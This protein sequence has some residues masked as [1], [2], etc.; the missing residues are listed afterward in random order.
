LYKAEDL[1]GALP[2]HWM[3]WP[4][5]G[6][7]AV[8]L[9][10]LI[11]PHALGV[12]YDV[13]GDL[14][15][16]HLTVRQVVAILLVK[17]IIWIIALASGTSGGVLA[18]LLIFGGCLGWLE[19]QVLPGNAG[20]WAL[21]SMAGMM[22]GTMR[23]PLTGI[24]FAIELTGDLAL[25][26]PLLAATGAAYAVT[27]LLLKRSILTEKIARRG[28]HVVR[29]YSIDPFELLRVSDVMVRDVDTLP[30]E[31][32]V[33]QAIA[34]FSDD[35]H[36]HKSYPI[37][38]RDRRVIGMV[39]RADILRW[40]TEPEAHG[41]TLFERHSDDQLVVGHEDE[42]VAQLADRMAAEE[43]GR[44]PIIER[45]TARLVGLVSRKD[46]L[47]IRRKA[48]AAEEQRAAYFLKSPPMSPS[49]ALGQS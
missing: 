11:E 3:W 15:G 48:R 14:L 35:A 19:G 40:R 17:S 20:A 21:I 37:L 45:S 6:G 12:G 23:S 28:Q 10:G 1:F 34:F 31:M 30:A 44:V 2:I 42:P 43:V 38:G 4:A 49:E 24:L 16:S 32:T 36:R 9:G 13:I 22:G 33:D 18:P 27:V 47:R 5:L 29:E 46:L 41:E 25:L 39:S 8:G 26:G 7:L